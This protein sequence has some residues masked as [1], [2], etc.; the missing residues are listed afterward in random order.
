[1]DIVSIT[2]VDVLTGRMDV[3]PTIRTREAP[4]ETCL[5]VSSEVLKEDSREAA[6][7]VVDLLDRTVADGGHKVPMTLDVRTLR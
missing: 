2:M 7:M 3:I 1:M 6:T 4:R 5:E